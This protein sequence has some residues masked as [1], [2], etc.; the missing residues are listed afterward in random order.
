MYHTYLHLCTFVH[1]INTH[2][3]L[4]YKL[5]AP[6]EFAA[7]EAEPKEAINLA[8]ANVYMAGNIMYYVLTHQWLFEGIINNDTKAAILH[9]Q[10][11]RIPPQILAKATND[12]YIQ[13]ML[14]GIDM[15]W[16]HDPL[17]RPSGRDIAN[18]LKQQLAKIEGIADVKDV[19][20][21]RVHMPPLPLDHRYTDNDF[22]SN[23]WN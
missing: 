12:P 4:Y 22:Y 20:V 9:G 6:E 13:T 10:R 7:L 8:P 19:G 3:L 17:L 2:Y 23:I 18:Y 14:N 1:D 21:I 16:T 5:R 11:S 15:C